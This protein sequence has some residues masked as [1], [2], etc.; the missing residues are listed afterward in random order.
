MRWITWT[1]LG[2]L[3]L[4]IPCMLFEYVGFQPGEMFVDTYQGWG[5]FGGSLGGE[6]VHYYCR[7]HRSLFVSAKLNL[8]SGWDILHKS[9]EL[10]LGWMN[11][12]PIGGGVQISILHPWEVWGNQPAFKPVL[13]LKISLSNTWRLDKKTPNKLHNRMEMEW[14]E[15]CYNGSTH[16]NLGNCKKV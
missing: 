14:D 16:M 7:T 1:T 8:Q 4:K 2:W 15:Q 12:Q 9:S 11:N 3:Q 13:T 6:N 10:K 5:Q